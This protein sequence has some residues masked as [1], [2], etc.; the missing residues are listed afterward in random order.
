MGGIIQPSVARANI[1]VS[2]E[3]P[4]GTLH[5]RERLKD[6]VGI[7][8]LGLCS[9][10]IQSL[11]LR[12]NYM[13]SVLQQHVLFWDRDNDGIIWPNHTYSGFRRLGFNILFSAFAVMVI[14]GGFSYP[15]RLEFSWLPDPFFRVY[16]QSIHKAKVRQP[17]QLK[18]IR[19]VSYALP[20]PTSTGRIAWCTTTRGASRHSTLKTYFP[21]TAT[22]KR[23]HCHFVKHS[24]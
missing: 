17:I 7:A 2:T 11:Q 5:H 1:A 18:I 21:N 14:H 12:P 23:A 6:Y 8:V 10:T 20:V 3:T 24:V 9:M 13:Q 19:S 15:T 16:V 4:D 22:R